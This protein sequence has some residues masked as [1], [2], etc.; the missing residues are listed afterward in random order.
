[1][2][3]NQSIIV[4]KF[5]ITI[6]KYS[7]IVILLYSCASIKPP[8]GGSVDE[9]PPT[10]IAVI[11]LSG[12]ANLTSNKIVLKF[13]EYM[14]ENS[15]KNNIQVYPR[16]SKPLAWKFKGDEIILTLPDS[17]DMEKTY[18]IYL[19][20]NIKDE[21]G[22]SLAKTIQ[23]AYSTGDKV[24]GGEIY[25]K[26][27]GS[28]QMSVHLWKIN[29]STPDSLFATQPDYIT[30]VNE[31]GLYS[32]SHLAPGNYQVLAIEKSGAGLP[33]NTDHKGY[34][35]N[36]QEKL[37]LSEN[38]TLS[39]INM[40]LWKEPQKLKLIRGEWSAFTWGKLFFNNELPESI[41]VD[42]QLKSEDERNIDLLQYYLDPIDQK[43]LIVQVSDSLVQNSL[44]V[45]IV[46]L[47]LKNELLLDSTEIVIQIPQ[48]AD[49]SYLQILKPAPNFQIFP[50]N[51]TEE[52]LDIIFSKPV[53]LSEDS[54]LTPKLFK[55]DSIPI[56]ANIKQINPI[57]L[58]LI[59]VLKWEENEKYQLKINREGII[60]EDCR[61]L[62]DS[63]TTINLQT[64]KSTGY[65]TVTG[66]ISELSP[67]NLA[68][69]LF[70][71]KNP[72]LSQMTIV[73]SESEFEFKTIPEG[74]Y[75]LYFF[76]DS[77]NDM[78]YSFGNAYPITPCEWFYFYPDTFEV[79]ANWETE[80][81]PIKLPD[82]K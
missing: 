62:K 41:T 81:A 28:G 34:G 2:I 57:Q 53:Q 51:L 10:I 70:S 44:K 60:V 8:P 74:N 54:L 31:D 27:Y 58:Q 67:S 1:M 49:T 63:I 25:G 40:R 43:N 24:S 21:H 39:N 33:L 45:N 18:I 46:S 22:V 50:N 29:G 37:N 55:N 19:N 30:D 42:L 35:L 6:I 75:S 20:R 59:P 77:D 38:D 11:P 3:F 5:Y 17:L 80:I 16:L 4:V 14:D 47:N 61:G 68:V 78:K 76:K 15:F 64:T 82:I 12:T 73:N 71:A 32:F 26:I 52:E 79:R 72:S 9:T 36:W 48:E 7:I 69:E 65:G 23:L 56:N 13:S 66:K